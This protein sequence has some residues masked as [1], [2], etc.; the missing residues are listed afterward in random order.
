[1]HEHEH[2]YLDAESWISISLPFLPPY[3]HSESKTVNPDIVNNTH[4]ITAA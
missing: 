3:E 4:N 2:N 1:M